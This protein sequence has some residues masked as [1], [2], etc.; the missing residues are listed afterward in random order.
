VEVTGFSA[1]GTAAA[2]DVDDTDELLAWSCSR[3][4]VTS[5]GLRQAATAAHEKPPMMAFSAYD[6][7]LFAA[8]AAAAAATLS[9]STSTA[10]MARTRVGVWLNVIMSEGQSSVFQFHLYN[11]STIPTC[12]YLVQCGVVNQVQLNQ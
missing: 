12:R 8:A 9:L 1:E 2:E 11:H 10:L 5:S 3:M 7:S 4:R 6:S